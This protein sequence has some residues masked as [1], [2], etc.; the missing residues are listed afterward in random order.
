MDHQTALSSQAGERYTLGEL[1]SPEREEFEE[2][3][4]GC[5]DCADALKEHEAFAVNVRAV[6][7]EDDAAASAVPRPTAAQPGWWTGVRKWFAVPAIALAGAIFAFML[8]RA[9]GAMPDPNGERAEWALAT[10]SRAELEPH[11]ISKST[12]WISPTVELE[13][14]DP[15]RWL[16]YHWELRD[17]H[18]L[19]VADGE[20]TAKPFQLKIPSAKIVSNE[21][22]VLKVQGAHGT[23]P[24]YSRFAITRK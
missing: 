8:V 2:H 19:L 13:G 3:F 24:V 15:N 21:M 9:P 7:K 10:A 12:V 1:N 20:G 17:S 18:D 4:F 23:E 11:A 22:Y 14:M 5:T 6:F 16:T